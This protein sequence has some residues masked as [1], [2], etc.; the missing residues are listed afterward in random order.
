MPGRKL[1]QDVFALIHHVQLNETGWLE[2]SVCRAVKFLMWLIDAPTTVEEI[3]TSQS[4][5]GLA[6]LSRQNVDEALTT[7]TSHNEV[8][9]NGTN[10][11]KLSEN[12]RA[13]IAEE[14]EVAEAT[15]AAVRTKV[16]TA[17]IGANDSLRGVDQDVLWEAFHK[18]FVVPFIQDFGA[19]AYELITGNS[20]ASEHSDALGDL[21]SHVPHE[22]QN[23][24]RAMVFALLD[25]QSD[26]SRRYVLRL[27]NSYFFQ[28]A[29]RIP[30]AT[31]K[32]VFANRVKRPIRLVL[33]TNFLF[34][35]LSL[36][37]NPSN[38]AVQLLVQT[39]KSVP[40]A[41]DVRMYVLPTTILEFQR[42]LSNYEAQASQIRVTQNIVEAGVQAQISGVI[43]TYLRRCQS[44]NYS[45]SAKEYFAPYYDGLGAILKREG[46]EVLQVDEQ[47]YSSDQRVIDDAQGQLAFHK[48]RAKGDPRR[49]RSWD[50]IWH[51]VLLW[52]AVA[53][54]RQNSP[55]TLFDAGWLAVTIDYSLVAFDSYKRSRRG[56]PCVVHPASLAQ[57]F[58]LLVPSNV[59]FEQATFLLMQLPFLGEKFDAADEKATIRI[60]SALSRYENIDDLKVEA[61]SEL[62]G[63]RALKAKIEKAD[64]NPGEI[65]LI[66]EALIEHRKDMEAHHAEQIGK[67]R[68]KFE[69][70]A[71]VAAEQRGRAD[72]L[73]SRVLKLENDNE[74]LKRRSEV[75]RFETFTIAL[76]AGVG[77]V[78]ALVGYLSWSWL[79]AKL[80]LFSTIA[81]LMMPLPIALKMTKGRLARFCY[82]G[83]SRIAKVIESA[84]R[85]F[86]FWLVVLTTAAVGGFF[87]DDVKSLWHK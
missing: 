63:D 59:K 76:M 6:F 44:S 18:E 50:Q 24:M 53:D 42:T 66:R 73:T 85:L 1:G 21:I 86:W 48:K 41:I 57:M 58:Q 72:S 2:H 12:E 28:T 84:D 67:L 7:L 80:S 62:L 78:I 30:D 35:L 36:H 60:L 83:D 23:E 64:E 54:R 10:T 16:I 4:Q 43:E 52:Y 79:R 19:R 32:S 31:I 26:D 39:I 70:E 40:A 20:P 68:E 65:E 87:Y 77:L 81:I 46:I 37:E 11:Y 38:E 74:G 17:A 13:K 8:L 55:L 51:D 69:E 29:T 22:K 5:A 47:N 49:E 56:I 14:I 3:V 75:Q 27:L 34:S 33:D 71:K 25:H 61:I 15:E 82:A 45:I 9:V